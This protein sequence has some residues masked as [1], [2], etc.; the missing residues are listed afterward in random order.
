MS[1]ISAF[2]RD[3]ATALGLTGAPAAGEGSGSPQEGDAGSVVLLHGLGRSETS[4]V[5]LEGMLRR[6]ATGPSMSAT[7]PRSWTSAGS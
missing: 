5:V 3:V 6:P 2:A 1:P 7:P 4:L